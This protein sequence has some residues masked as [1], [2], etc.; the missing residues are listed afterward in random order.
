MTSNLTRLMSRGREFM[1][2]YTNTK[3]L[4]DQI[5]VLAGFGLQAGHAGADAAVG[6]SHCTFLVALCQKYVRPCASFAAAQPS[7]SGGPSTVT[8]VPARRAATF[9]S[10][11]F[12]TATTHHAKAGFAAPAHPHQLFL[13]PTSCALSGDETGTN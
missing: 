9:F 8:A 6:R 12:S 11:V 1:T 4:R 5:K 13:C 10:K 3:S 2:I 7:G